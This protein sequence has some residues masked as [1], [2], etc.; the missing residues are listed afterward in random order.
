VNGYSFS[1]Y[2]VFT[3]AGM[4]TVNI[5]GNG[6]PI[7]AQ[8]DNFTATGSIDGGTCTFPVTVAFTPLVPTVYNPVTGKTWRDRN[9]GATRVANSSTD[10][11]A[12]GYRLQWG[13]ALD[14][15][16]GTGT[17]ST[18]AT[19]PLPNAGN[20]WD[21]L[22][23]LSGISPNDWLLPQDNNLWQGVTGTNNPCPEG[24]RIPT[25]A[26]W[27]AER[28]SWT[29]NDPV[30][31]FASP[32]KIPIAGNRS[33]SNGTVTYGTGNYWS[34]TVSNQGAVRLLLME[35]YANIAAANA[36]ATGFSIRCIKD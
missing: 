2:G 5:N 34:S 13:R 10:A 11:S 36:R 18:I 32:L 14:G 23:I 12:Y 20:S 25:E 31:A 28:L 1:K 9:S 33:Y 16:Q 19:T 29:S 26:E 3:S 15:H 27:E 8:T 17:T 30:G 24:F 6:K 7:L 21:G 22:F 4:Q 35:G